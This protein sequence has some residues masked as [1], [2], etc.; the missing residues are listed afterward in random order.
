MPLVARAS[1]KSSRG[2]ELVNL[3]I[4]FIVIQTIVLIL[5]YISRYAKVK[6][7]SGVE[8][9]YFMPLGYMFCIGNAVCAILMVRLGGM[10][11]HVLTLNAEEILMLGKVFKAEE[12]IYLASVMFPKLAAL[13]LY[14]RLFMNPVRRLSYIVG[15]FVVCSFLAGWLTWAFSCRPFAFNWNKTIPGGHCINTNMSYTYFSIPNLLSDL[16]LILLPLH[17]LWKLNV[18]RSQRIGLLVTF[19][20]G[21][22]GIVTAII[23]FV[24]FITTDIRSDPSFHGAT[25]MRWGIIEPA[26][27]QMAATL[28]TLRPLLTSSMSVLSRLSSK[29]KLES[30]NGGTDAGAEI[31]SGDRNHFVKLD[32]YHYLQDSRT[33]KGLGKK[34]S[35]VLK[36]TNVSVTSH[37]TLSADEYVMGPARP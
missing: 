30:S 37:T 23:R 21:G 29:S 18:A 1:P 11:R 24:S 28:P 35:G 8:M 19:V 25:T 13:S 15:A 2:E 22:F 5:F 6:H 20:L 4:A 7:I 36:T 3:A 14:I 16:A 34:Y 12:M 17:P 31:A 32:D 26:M 9:K 27:Y 33:S 10:G